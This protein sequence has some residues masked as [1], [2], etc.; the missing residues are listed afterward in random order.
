MKTRLL[1]FVVVLSATS[2]AQNDPSPGQDQLKEGVAAYKSGRYADAVAHFQ[3]ALQLD[4]NNLTVQ[5][6]LATAYYIQ[7]VPGV[8]DPEN[9]KNYAMADKQFRAV[10]DKDPKNDLALA[11]LASMTYNSALAG[12]P[13]QKSAALD[14]SMQWNRKRVEVNPNNP[15]PYYYL[16]VIDWS[17]V[18][19]PIQAARAKLQIGPTDPGPIHD[20]AT[21]VFLQSQYGPTLEDGLASL[22]KC[23]ALDPQNEDAMTYLNL[24]LRKEADLEDLPDAAKTDIAQA[25]DWADKALET[26]KM[27][28]ESQQPAPADDQQV[29]MLHVSA[30]D[31]EK[32]LIRKVQPVYSDYARS[33][34]M[35]GTVEFTIVID[36]TG[37]VE[38]VQLVKANPMF[39][40][41]AKDAIM[42][43]KYKP[44]L[45]NG[46][47]VKV[48]TEAAVVFAL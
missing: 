41:A 39:V 43:W 6:Y 48:T 35:Q 45:L 36:A 17:K 12:T 31:A 23:L 40:K 26:K 7:W 18:Y 4:P 44:F 34:R 47:A 28:A 20:E 8:A 33:M 16:G 21:R 24:L 38:S 15:E 14:E 3:S 42:Q 10:I 5:N 11:M 2:L 25:N 1:L 30:A 22:R 27:K 29:A 46:Q 19:P 9:Q 32:N 37:N 13:A